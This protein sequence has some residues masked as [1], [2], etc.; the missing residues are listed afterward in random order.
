VRRGLRSFCPLE[1]R[2]EPCGEVDGVSFFNDSKATN[3]DATLKA[4]GSFGETPLIMLYGGTDKG[5]ELDALVDR[6]LKRCKA[7]VCYGAARTRFIEAFE[8]GLRRPYGQVASCTVLAAD[9][10]ADALQVAVNLAQTG[11]TICLSPACASFDEFTSFEQR[12][13]V[14]KEMVADLKKA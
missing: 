5:T 10:L 3:V 9:H 4:L 14:F 12:G 6:T 7:V 8:D 2:N 13:V 11:D 1:H